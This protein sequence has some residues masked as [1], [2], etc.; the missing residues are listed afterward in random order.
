MF[1]KIGPRM[2][3]IVRLPLARSSSIDFGADDVGRHEIGGELDAVEPEIDRFGQPL[4][5]Q[6]LGKAGHAPQQTVAAGEK[7]N[8]DLANDPLLPDDDLRQFALEP[9]RGRGDLIL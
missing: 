8:Q 7:G 2:N 4:D 9:R 6:G 5:E 3:R 1:A